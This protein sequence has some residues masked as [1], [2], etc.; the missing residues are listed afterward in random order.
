MPIKA[1]A[2]KIKNEMAK[3]GNPPVFPVVDEAAEAAAAAAKAA[4]A[5][6][7]AKNA[8]PTKFAAKKSK[9]VAKAGTAAYQWQIMKSSGVPEGDIPP[10]ADPYHWLD[11]FPP[12]AK[13]DV[14]AMGCQVDWRRS[15]IT[16]DH[17]PFYDAFVRWQFNTLK[18]I[19]KIIKAKRMAVYS[20]LDG[21]PCADHDRATGEGVGPQEYV[22]VKM[23]VYDEW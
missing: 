17:N 7:T 2:D 14:T 11:Y 12:L 19:G 5:A 23:R 21:Q 22:L 20:P 18:S 3:F 4:K 6:D 1:S 8:D 15:F 9:A 13:R 16:T 10:F